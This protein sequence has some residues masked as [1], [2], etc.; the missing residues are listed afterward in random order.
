MTKLYIRLGAHLVDAMTYTPADNTLTHTVVPVDCPGQGYAEA[1]RD[2]VYDNPGLLPESYD[3]ATI[4]VDTR[5]RLLLPCEVSDPLLQSQLMRASDTADVMPDDAEIIDTPLRGVDAR[6]VTA[7]DARLTNYLRRTYVNPDITC[8]LAPQIEYFAAKSRL[9]GN[10]RCYVNLRDDADGTID[11]VVMND[12]RPRLANSYDAPTDADA[13]YYVLA[14]CEVTG[15]D[16]DSDDV[17]NL[18]GDHARRE[19][20]MPMLRERH[21]RVMP[22]IFPPAIYRAGRDAQALPF[23]LVAAATI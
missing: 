22:V 1:L 11:I 7:L 12:G 3:S 15:F 16:P 14:A 4:V 20:L 2:A 5:A 10:I 17:I 13:L 23:D 18:C 6:I 21:R 8:T 9:S 19:R